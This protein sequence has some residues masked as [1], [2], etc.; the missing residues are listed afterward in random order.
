MIYKWYKIINKP[1][2]EATGLVSRTVTL[3]LEGIGLRSVLVT[4]GN[5][6]SVTYEDTMLSLSADG[7]NPFEFNGL[8]LYLDSAGDVWLGFTP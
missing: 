2:F 8:A 4:N 1:E 6:F 3:I 7:H 5:F